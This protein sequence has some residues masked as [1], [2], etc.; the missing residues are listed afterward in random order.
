MA[1]D[2]G[3]RETGGDSRQAGDR[4]RRLRY[5]KGNAVDDRSVSGVG[6]GR[7]RAPPPRE[8]DGPRGCLARTWCRVQGEG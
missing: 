2:P 4:W 3:G 5:P 8:V 6:G 7:A 1:V